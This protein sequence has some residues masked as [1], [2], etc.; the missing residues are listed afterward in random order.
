MATHRSLNVVH[1]N[2]SFDNKEVYLLTIYNKSES[3]KIDDNTL[4][5]IK[6]PA[7]VKI[8]RDE[9]KTDQKP[10]ARRT[11]TESKKNLSRLNTDGGTDLCP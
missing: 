7:A 10:S 11:E 1:H 6:Q 5:S 3:G 9:N 8:D 2:K 4:K